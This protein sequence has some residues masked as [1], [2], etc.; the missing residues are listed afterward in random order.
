MNILCLDYGTKR[1]GV[2]IATT[3]LAQPIGVITNTKNPRLS[4]IVSDA[5]LHQIENVIKEFGIEKILVGISEGTMADKSRSFITK[6]EERTGLSI[7]EIDETLSSVSATDSM[8]HMK[9]GKKR[10]DRDHIAAAVML[11]EY[12]DL[13]ETEVL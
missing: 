7:E 9:K 5:A 4:D 12:L 13:H 6:L 11:Q 1:I 8:S 10:G 3:P 2:A